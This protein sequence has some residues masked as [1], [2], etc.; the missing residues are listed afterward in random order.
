MLDTGWTIQV[1]ELAP[2]C[3]KHPGP[4]DFVMQVKSGAENKML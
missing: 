4:T 2:L 3:K 1:H